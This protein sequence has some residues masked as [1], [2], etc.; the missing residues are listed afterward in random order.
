MFFDCVD[1]LWNADRLRDKRMSLEM[2]S[3]LCLNM[4]DQRGQENYRR[5][6]QFTISFDLCR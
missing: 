6:V 4:R 3:T 5:V 2:K 1:Q